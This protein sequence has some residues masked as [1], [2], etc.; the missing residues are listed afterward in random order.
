[1]VQEWYIKYK[2][3]IVILLIVYATPLQVNSQNN[4]TMY[5]CMEKYEG[6]IWGK[7]YPFDYENCKDFRWNPNKEDIEQ[8]E[9]LVQTFIIQQVKKKNLVNQVE[10]RLI[11]HLNMDKYLRQYMGTINSKGEKILEINCF[12]KEKVNEFPYWK[13]HVVRVCDGGSFYWSIK[14]N[15]SKKKCFD[16]MINGN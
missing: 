1:M 6:I 13:T 15:M 10:G 16:Y 2:A 5:I 9:L 7:D 11:I 3:F 14:V 12:W 4:D 8:A